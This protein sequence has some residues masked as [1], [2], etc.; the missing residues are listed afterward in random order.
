MLVTGGLEFRLTKLVRIRVEERFDGA[1]AGGGGCSLR[2]RDVGCC[3]R[4]SDVGNLFAVRLVLLCYL[5]LPNLQALRCWL[6]RQTALITHA[7]SPF[8][9]RRGSCNFSSTV[10]CGL[11]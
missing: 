10:D 7:S 6:G 4:V 11:E 2:L 3:I 5:W 1:V 8:V 9:A